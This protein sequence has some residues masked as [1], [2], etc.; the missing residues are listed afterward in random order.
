MTR[1]DS[2]LIALE[3]VKYE[4]QRRGLSDIACKTVIVVLDREQGGMEAAAKAD[5]ELLSLIPFKTVGLP[6][7]KAS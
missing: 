1:F 7:L 3:Q 6:L 4:I 5:L 2:K